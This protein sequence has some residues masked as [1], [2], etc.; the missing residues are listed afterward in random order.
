VLAKTF[1]LLNRTMMHKRTMAVKLSERGRSKA[2]CVLREDYEKM[3][4]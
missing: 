3:V 2:R 4:N 1:L